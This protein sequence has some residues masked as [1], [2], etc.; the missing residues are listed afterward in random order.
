VVF[1]WPG[2]HSIFANSKVLAFDPCGVLPLP[3]TI[4]YTFEE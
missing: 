4:L 1:H 3:Q 2:W